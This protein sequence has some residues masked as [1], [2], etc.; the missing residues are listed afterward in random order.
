M[1]WFQENWAVAVPL[2]GAALGWVYAAIFEAHTRRRDQRQREA[3]RLQELA[4][5][6][7]NKDYEHGGW[8]QVAAVAELRQLKSQRT[9]VLRIAKLAR[10][11]WADN[12]HRPIVAELDDLIRKL[13]RR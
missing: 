7:Y 8:A 10:D 11:H 3:A 13:S 9:A 5:V 12:E 6:L 2:L 1:G 4:K